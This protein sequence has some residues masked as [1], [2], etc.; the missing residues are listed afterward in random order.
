M[1]KININL[2]TGTFDSEEESIVVGIDLGTTNSLIA[3]VN[4]NDKPIAIKDS[5][6]DTLV[7]SVVYFDENGSTL[8]GKNAVE[9]SIYNPQNTIYSVKRL[10]GKKYSEI[11]HYKQQLNYKIID[12]DEDKLL[13]IQVNDVFYTPIQL[14]AEILKELKWRAEHYLRKKISKAVITVPAYFND[15]QR[16]ATRD[17]GKLA[18]LDVLRIINEPTAAGLAYGIGVGNNTDEIIAVYDLGGGTF[19]ISIMKIENGVYE[20]IATNGDT[21]LGGDDFD[22]ALIQ[23]W[24]KENQ[25]SDVDASQKTILKFTAEKAKKHLTNHEV[26]E[27]KW[28]NYV[29]KIDK[30]T[31]N[32]LIQPLVERS[33]NICQKALHDAKLTFEDIHKVVMVGGSTRVPLVQQEV[34]RFF[35][36]PLYHD[37]NP[38]EVVA[39][40]AAVQAQILSGK[41]K[42][43]LLLDVTPLSLGI[44]T[45]GDLMDTLIP[46]NSKIPCKASRQ[47]TTSVDGQTKMKIS[48]FQGEREQVSKNRKLGEFELN[49]IPAMPAGF[50]KIE[51][52]FMLNADGILKVSAKELRSNVVQEVEIKSQYGLSDA[53]VEK[54]LR[55]SIENAQIDVAFKALKESE[56]EAKN[57][58][59]ASEKFLRNNY[60]H[61]LHEE[62]IEIEQR[63][64]ALKLAIAS[65]EKNN[66][67]LQIQNLNTFSEPIAQRVMDYTVREALKGNKI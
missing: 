62:K 50:P 14:S 38:D 60:A 19:D 40:G 3:F 15:N 63:I 36:K 21:L 27:K 18:G 10:L 54:L 17:A 20:V 44:E 23:F 11:A 57:I 25:I 1:A 45:L 26:F 34:E 49:N 51:V 48:V 22:H 59:Y 24:M 52:S 8:V 37:I 12:N 6:K 64:R 2:Q 35:K 53:E 7:P 46:R 31:F 32:S 41:N 16:Q 43:V 29:F 67:D 55:E 33:I 5:D 66:I 4:E 56:N 30:Q 39:L 47:Y 61:I 58:L 42:D 65:A 9:N 28:E 13:K